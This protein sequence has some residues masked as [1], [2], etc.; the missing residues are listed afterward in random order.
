MGTKMDNSAS[1]LEELPGVSPLGRPRKKG[2]VLERDELMVMAS[3]C[4][5]SMSG[6]VSCRRWSPGKND[7]ERL[8]WSRALTAMLSAYNSTLKDRDL[9]SIRQRLDVIEERIT[10]GDER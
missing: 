9:E 7:K 6:R 2:T 3:D 1:N 4:L 8:A 5:R 10:K